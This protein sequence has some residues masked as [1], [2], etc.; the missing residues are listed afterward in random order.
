LR[1]TLAR[2]LSLSLVVVA[3][4]FLT[5]P[6][7]AALNGTVK[8]LIGSSTE[9]FRRP[10]A[11]GEVT[12]SSQ[13]DPGPFTGY[14]ADAYA[15]IMEMWITESPDVTFRHSCEG[16]HEVYKNISEMQGVSAK[17]DN[18]NGLGC[19]SYTSTVGDP[20]Y[21]CP[22]YS[23][24][25]PTLTY[26]DSDLASSDYVTIEA[27]LGSSIKV[28]G[29]LS[30]FV[31]DHGM[32]SL[33][34]TT[35]T[36]TATPI[37]VMVVVELK[38]ENT[39][40][41]ISTGNATLSLAGSTVGF[42]KSGLL[43]GAALVVSSLPNSTYQVDLAPV[44]AALTGLNMTGRTMSVE[45]ASSQGCV[46]YPAITQQPIGVTVSPGQN[47]VLHVVATTPGGTGSLS[48]AWCRTAPGTCLAETP[49]VA[50]GVFTDTLTLHDVQAGDVGDY[51]CVIENTCGPTTTAVAP[52]SLS[53]GLPAVS[54]WSLGILVLLVTITGL[55]AIRRQTS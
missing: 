26:G 8:T 42:A 21:G 20:E 46:S 19:N 22:P 3:P 23:F 43:S 27:A 13:C 34:T 44:A 24:N 5:V 29:G 6:A 45:L 50:T 12:H 18:C 41:V 10:Y 48:Y 32:L 36:L 51:F 35:P 49:G 17:V 39:N 33:A 38:D 30:Q 1:T 54:L 52:V 15:G 2:S 55:L 16:F 53:V 25:C 7:S 37:Q 31:V 11:V 4:A 40:T 47:A 28:S 14:W 9:A